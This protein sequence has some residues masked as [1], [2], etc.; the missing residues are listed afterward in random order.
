MDVADLTLATFTFFN[1]LR[2]F[3]YIPQIVRVARDRHGALAISYST[4]GMWT[5]ANLST[6]AYAFVNVSDPWLGVISL[7]NTAG[8]AAVI[9]LAI[10]KRVQY[11][12]EQRA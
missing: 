5:G 2:V 8:C 12:R 1:A 11:M 6:A 3:S 4:W 9:A 7:F 10:R